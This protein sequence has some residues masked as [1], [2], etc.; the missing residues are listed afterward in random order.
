MDQNFPIDIQL[1]KMTNWM[2]NR[3]LCQKN[4][5]DDVNA[6]RAKI[7]SAIQDMP[8]HPTI[9]NLLSASNINYY[10]CK[11]ILDVLKETE[12]DSKNILGMYTSTRI[13]DWRSICQMYE[14]GNCYLPEAS[15]YL[16]QAV[17]YEIPSLKKQVAKQEKQLNDL[18]KLEQST[19]RKI[20]ELKN[21]RNADCAKMGIEGANPKRELLEIV[22]SLPNLYERW[23]NDARPNLKPLMEKYVEAASNHRNSTFCLPTLSFLLQ[24]GNVTAYEYI[25][26]EGR[27]FKGLLQ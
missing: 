15:N 24:K 21:E 16:N 14:K 27:D 23:L 17:L 11:A 3:R 7:A 12:K 20:A 25:H 18:D 2:E 13:T 4:W 19:K 5:H 10:S 6:V 22:H 26:G 9:K 8:E 1:K